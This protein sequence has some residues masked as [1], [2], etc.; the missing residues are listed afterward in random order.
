MLRE[1]HN[2]KSMYVSY[3]TV[4]QSL[5]HCKNSVTQYTLCGSMPVAAQSDYICTQH[6]KAGL[7]NAR[8]ACLLCEKP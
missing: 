8:Q 7:C 3:T 5:F 4:G 1:N 2:K 6:Y